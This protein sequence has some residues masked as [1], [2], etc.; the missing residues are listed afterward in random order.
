MVAD[1]DSG[2]SVA[3]Q[4][5]TSSGTFLA[6]HEVINLLSSLPCRC[7]QLTAIAAT[8]ARGGRD[9]SEH[10]NKKHIQTQLHAKHSF[11]SKI[12]QTVTDV[13]H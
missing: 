9:S 4:A 6:K 7:A 2:K 1:N 12:L 11:A 8:D 3:S 13:G 5:R 10:V